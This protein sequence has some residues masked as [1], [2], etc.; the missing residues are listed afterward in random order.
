MPDCLVHY[1]NNKNRFQN[2]HNNTLHNEKK[3]N[4]LQTF[5]VSISSLTSA[6]LKIGKSSRDNTATVD[7]PVDDY[8]NNKLCANSHRHSIHVLTKHFKLDSALPYMHW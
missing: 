2:N 5:D 1:G 6:E 3:I 8:N 7:D 4:N